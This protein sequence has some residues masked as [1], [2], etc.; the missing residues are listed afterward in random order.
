[1]EA[2]DTV[3]GVAEAH[4]TYQDD[5]SRGDRL[6]WVCKAQAEISFKAGY[7]LCEKE[8]GDNYAK[9]YQKAHEEIVK[10][11]RRAGIREVV[12]YFDEQVDFANDEVAPYYVMNEKV[13]QAKLKEWGVE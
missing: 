13:W 7:E 5:K 9:S 6:L 4:T 10:A 12:E 8:Y 11:E 3:M 1:M 2:K